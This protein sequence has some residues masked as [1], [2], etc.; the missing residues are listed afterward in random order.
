MGTITA[1]GRSH[2]LRLAGGVVVLVLFA[3][4][5]VAATSHAT[6]HRHAR[7]IPASRRLR[8]GEGHGARSGAGSAAFCNNTVQGPWLIAD[9]RG[10]VCARANLSS[11][12]GCCLTGDPYT[13]DTCLLDMYCCEQYEYC[14]SCC[15][16]PKYDAAN[17]YKQMYRSPDRAETG[18]WDSPFEYCRGK[19]R[20]TSRSTVHENAYLAPAHHCFSSSGKPRTVEPPTPELAPGTQ[21]LAGARGAS[22]ETACSAAGGSCLVSQLAAINNC[23]IL[24]DHF[25]CEAGCAMGGEAEHPGYM[26]AATPK[27]D[28]P[29]MCFT[30]NS[31]KAAFS[32][33]TLNTNS[34]RLCACSSTA[35]S[36]R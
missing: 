1:Q 22:C 5:S 8:L 26:V 13:C 14:V 10:R 23:N 29:T 15:L 18:Y 25:A 3:L 16:S 36:S 9:D 4:A 34:Q 12:T 30:L 20:T 31:S 27:Q 17:L 21:V 7:G 28:R 24:R 6:R 33:S 11:S 32:C 35:S 19:C 2:V